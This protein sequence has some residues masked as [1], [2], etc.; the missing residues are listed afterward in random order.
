MYIYIYGSDQVSAM[1]P[2]PF[3]TL[4]W[5]KRKKERK[6]PNEKK[7]VINFVHVY[8]SKKKF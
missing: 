3:S 6:K 5:E 1:N 2:P 8:T 4:I 7:C